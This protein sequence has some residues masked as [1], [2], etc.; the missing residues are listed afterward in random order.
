M[1][2]HDL[3]IALGASLA[4]NTRTVRVG[5]TFRI[6]YPGSGFT[7]V[8]TSGF[9]FE[10]TDTLDVHRP[11]GEEREATKVGQ[12]PFRCF[13]NGVEIQVAGE[14]IVDPGA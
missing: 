3:Q 5:D 12:F 8:Y 10:T 14:I 4:A 7:F 2:H 13:R 6:F 1:P 9:P 11:G